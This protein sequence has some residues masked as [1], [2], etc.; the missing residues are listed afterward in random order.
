MQVTLEHLEEAEAPG[1]ETSE[2]TMG[3]E[4]L[5]YSSG[6]GTVTSIKCQER[7]VGCREEG[8]VLK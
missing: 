4:H 6:G 7:A 5:T 2:K 1:R 3:K 8:K